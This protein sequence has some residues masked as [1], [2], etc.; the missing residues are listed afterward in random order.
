[1]KRI[2]LI[3]FLLFPI[4]CYSANSHNVSKEQSFD[5]TLEQLPAKFDGNN[6]TSILRFVE[7]NLVKREKSEFETADAYE[8]RLKNTLRAILPNLSNG[9][10]AIVAHNAPAKTTNGYI[11]STPGKNVADP[12]SWRYQPEQQNLEVTAYSE[13]LFCPDVSMVNQVTITDVSSKERTYIGSNAYGA[14]VE[15]SEI[16]TRRD[17]ISFDEKSFR[18]QT[19]YSYNTFRFNS[20]IEPEKAQ[21]LKSDIAMLFVVRLK[22]PFSLKCERHK[23]PTID[24]PSAINFYFRSLF[25]DVAQVW[26]FNYRT[27]EVLR[28][29]KFGTITNE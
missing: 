15:V 5:P 27:G 7:K 22:P 25:V 13:T 9:Y 11:K 19:D 3:L 21:S 17:G 23:S 6:F 4:S 28:K 8:E 26:L 14:R 29:T 24:D 12:I 20:N 18:N 2:V 16:D 10:I 1:M